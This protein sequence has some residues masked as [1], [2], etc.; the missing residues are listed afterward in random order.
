[1]SK[2]ALPIHRECALPAVSLIIGSM[3]SGTTTL[4][5]HLAQ[6]PQVCASAMKEVG[7]FAFEEIWSLGPDWYAKHFKFD[8]ARHVIA[9]EASPDYSKTPFATG[10]PERIAAYG[11]DIKLIMIMRHPLR[12]IESHA[13]HVAFSGREVGSFL[14]PRHNHS[15]EFGVSPVSLAIS[16]Y[17]TQI[18]QYHRFYDSGRLLLLALEELQRYP[19]ET[20]QRIL[21]NS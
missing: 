4:F 3:K 16:R 2:A 14:S 5:E 13:R 6:H 8:R 10:V 1:M 20:M 12:R 11:S 9:L 21:S 19:G 18:D 7:Y 17:A 15:L